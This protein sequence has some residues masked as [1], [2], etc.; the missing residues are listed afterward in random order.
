M[1]MPVEAPMLEAANDFVAITPGDSTNLDQSGI[2]AIYVGGAG[3]LIVR[4]IGGSTSVTFAVVAGAIL[5]IR[6]GRVMTATT[7]TGL[8]GLI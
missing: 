4:K 8:V 2:R 5:P 7:A 1:P 6:V 3:N